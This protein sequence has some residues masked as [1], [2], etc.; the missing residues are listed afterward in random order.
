MYKFSARWDTN[1][2]TYRWPDNRLDT[3]FND[4]DLVDSS[5]NLTSN[6]CVA[7][8]NTGITAVSCD[9]HAPVACHSGIT[10]LLVNI[11]VAIIM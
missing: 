5:V 4:T 3:F 7:V 2:S 6:Q 8:S 11:G 9:Q 1:S 10:A